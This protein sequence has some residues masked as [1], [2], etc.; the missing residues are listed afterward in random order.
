MTEDVDKDKLAK[1]II[2]RND[3]PDNSVDILYKYK[4]RSNCYCAIAEV[5]C[6]S[7]SVM[8]KTKYDF[9]QSEHCKVYEHFNI[10]RCKNR[11]KKV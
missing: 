6:D 10:E 7:Y 8:M 2:E 3:L 1:N 9:L 11:G 4:Q 5:T